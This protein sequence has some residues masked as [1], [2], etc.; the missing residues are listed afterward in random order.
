MNRIAATLVLTMSCIA[1]AQHA[2]D[3]LPL[4]RHIK[5]QTITSL[6]APAAGLTFA[7]GFKYLGGQ[8]FTLYGVAEAEQHFFVKTAEDGS[9]QKFY[10]VQF[11]RYLSNNT[12]TYNYTQDRT[13]QLGGL[14]FSYDTSAYSDYAGM[15][16]NPASDGAA[17]SALLI[18]NGLTFPK[19]M[20]R[21]RMFHLPTADHRSELMIIYGESLPGDFSMP[22]GTDR[23][24]LDDTSPET[25]QLLEN[26]QKGLKIRKRR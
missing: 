11:E 14:S 15:N 13:V 9:I 18:K 23:V 1:F 3:S 7:K 24:S 4:Q 16:R 12:H 25:K 19:N 21:L 8:R 6:D 10:W 17:A 20:A 5:R 22:A 26:V 2:T